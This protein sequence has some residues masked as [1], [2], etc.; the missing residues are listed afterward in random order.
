MDSLG[1]KLCEWLKV[2]V[3]S[4]NA[5]SID[6]HARLKALHPELIVFELDFPRPGA[7]LTLLKEHPGAL[8]LGIDTTFSQVVALSSDWHL[9]QTMQEFCQL[10]QTKLNACPPLEG[11]KMN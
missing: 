1:S 3:I 10:A 11:R 7:I 6:F 9:T 5:T 2:D 8:F 4:M